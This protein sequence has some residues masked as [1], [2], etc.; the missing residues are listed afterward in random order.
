VTHESRERVRHEVAV[1]VD[2]DHA[3]GLVEHDEPVERL[4]VDE[5]PA[6]VPPHL[7]DPGL[8]LVRVVLEAGVPPQLPRDLRDDGARVLL[9]AEPVRPIEGGAEALE[10]PGHAGEVLAEAS[11]PFGD[12]RREDSEHLL[13]RV[14]RVRI[15]EVLGAL[16]VR[17]DR[18]LG[19]LDRLELGGERGVDPAVEA[20]EALEGEEPAAR[21][22]LHDLVDRGVDPRRGEGVGHEQGLEGREGLLEAGALD[23]HS[24]FSGARA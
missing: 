12:A 24:F 19:L 18:V 20:Q 10:R 17:A 9:L 1:G 7:V 6:Q 14:D 8:E 2:L 23:G 3:G 15:L 11:A 16:G 4:D 5:E 21:V 22:P 13:R